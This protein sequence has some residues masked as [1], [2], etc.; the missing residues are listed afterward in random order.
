MRHAVGRVVA[1]EGRGESL[2]RAADP[3]G[4]LVALFL[5]NRAVPRRLAA[6]VFDAGELRALEAMALVRVDATD[7]TSPVAVFPCGDL[8]IVTDALG[9]HGVAGKVMPLCAESYDL[10]ALI[11]GRDVGRALDLC[12]GSG[13]HALLASRHCRDVVG[14]DISP[15]AIAF[16]EFN[17]WFNR[18]S[19]VAFRRGDLYG[20]VE[21]AP[22]FDLITANPPYNPELDSPAGQDYH[23]G[24]E[25][26]EE[27]LSRIIEGAPR[28]LGEGGSC[29]VIT[30]LVLREGDTVR[31]KL[32]RWMGPMA[33]RFDVQVLSRP[34]EYRP[35]VLEGA[36]GLS[37]GAWALHASWKRQKICGFAFGV[38]SLRR[39][40]G[41][42]RP[43]KVE[44]RLGDARRSPGRVRAATASGLV[45]ELPSGRGR[46]S[47]P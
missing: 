26:G 44:R 30:L 6:R 46:G 22:G 45:E 29:H 39:P 8:L 36:A 38:V 33:S 2:L 32:R 10:A 41:G 18:I 42:R 5:F 34:V 47:P 4:I 28:F 43:R 25:S 12:T 40:P 14:I 3:L 21:S 16:A 35:A 9:N 19:R 7:V 24:G 20:P 23:S 11:R 27:V 13:V 37:P 17:A 31:R 1:D 15:R